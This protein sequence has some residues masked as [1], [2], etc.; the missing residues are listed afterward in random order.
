M[1][2]PFWRHAAIA[3]V[4]AAG[5]GIAA[6]QA[7]EAPRYETTAQLNQRLRLRVD[8]AN[9]RDAGKNRARAL[10][11]GRSVAGEEIIVVEIGRD[12][13]VGQ[14]PPDLSG[15]ERR[16]WGKKPALLCVA[17]IEGERIVGTAVA[18]TIVEKILDLPEAEFD[19]IFAD[20][21]LY[22]CAR[23]NPDG[24]A[25][26]FAPLRAEDGTNARAIDADRDGRTDEDP[27]DDL[28]GD[29]LC[30]WMRIKDARGSLVADSE[31]PRKMRGADAAKGERPVFSIFPEGKDD[32]GDGDL[33][34]DGRS[35]VAV[36]HNFPHGFIENR[37]ENGAHATSEPE[38]RALL[39][40]VLAR[41]EI[42][43][44]LVWG[45]HDN[46]AAIPEAGRA[47][48]AA[49]AAARRA[50]R[51]PA[52]KLHGDDR[53]IWVD[54]AKALDETAKRKV[55]GS[56][57][58]HGSLAQWA[59]FQ[60]GL[61]AYSV[62]LFEIADDA[63]ADPPTTQPAKDAESKP[64]ED[65]IAAAE[66]I[67]RADGFVAWH[68]VSHPTLGKV[69]VG[70]WKPFARFVPAESAILPIA[71][72]QMRFVVELLTR[73]AEVGLVEVSAK[74]LADGLF[75]ITAVLENRGKLPTSTMQGVTNGQNGPVI[76]EIETPFEKIV[77]GSKR[78]MFDRLRDR[79]GYENLRWVIRADP[80]ST[81]KI[82]VS[83]PKA[84]AFRKE[85]V[86]L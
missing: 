39:D 43:Q 13:D 76:V 9:R 22:V 68:E 17:G 62:N 78:R 82:L 70:G 51:A 12:L 6:A 40:Y 7:S 27:A 72:G 47:D 58:E 8:A 18:A 66:R 3:I 19:K 48:E 55:K 34:E 16:M 11:I 69:E 73:R 2:E 67:A 35:G 26:W 44:V 21:S 64:A 32:D 65:P 59:Y 71:E 45:A 42:A 24:A 50:G 79:A 56:A 23:L 86:L 20:Q 41:R 33:N 38:S 1:F 81:F 83:P 52:V 4:V 29:G 63:K 84:R 46:L 37:L 14:A 10:V 30:L 36:S 53:E 77:H 5:C 57:P 54:V 15:A 25:R 74:R 85:I 31:N 60:F 75:E 61:P 28:D 80:G 49:D